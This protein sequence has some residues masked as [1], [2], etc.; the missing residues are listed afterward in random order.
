MNRTRYEKR[1]LIGPIAL[2]V[3]TLF[4]SVLLPN[5]GRLANY[6]TI[7]KQSSF[8]CIAAMGM[9]FVLVSGEIDLS[10]GGQFGF[11]SMLC[12][13]LMKSGW[14]AFIAVPVTLLVAVA[15]GVFTGVS[16][17]VSRSNSL[18]LTIAVSV[19]LLGF[20]YMVGRGAPIFKIDELF[21][22]VMSFRVLG[23]SM[24]VIIMLVCVVLVAFL[25]RKTYWGKYLYAVGENNYA[26]GR[27][28][29]PVGK[30]KVIAFALCSFFMGIS[31]I[32]Y[33]GWVGSASFTA[34]NALELDVLTSA[35]IAGVHFNGGKGK[36]LPVFGSALFLGVLSAAFIA[37]N[38]APY[39]QNILKGII[40]FCAVVSNRT[41]S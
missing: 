40:L 32:S 3:T 9:L 21:W 34:G 41:Q 5:F 16:V 13:F 31:A 23:V 17:W 7:L 36:V 15:V 25:L 12:S 6:L 29:I 26:A 4:F 8:V 11:Y 14:A 39:Y 35:A 24:Q 2:V 28:G 33:L 18:L 27:S 30:T 37:L 10:I 38:V 20:T 1:E 19:V 22:K